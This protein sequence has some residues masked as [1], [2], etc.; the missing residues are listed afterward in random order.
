MRAYQRVQPLTIGELWAVAITLRIVLVE[1][2]RRSAERIVSSRAA[3]QEADALADRLLGEESREAELAGAALRGLEQRSLPREFAVQLDPAA[4]R[5]RSRGH[6]GPALA[7]RAS[8]APRAPPPTSSCARSTSAR[9]AMNVTVRNVITSMRLISAVD[10]A[11]FFESVSLVDEA[12]RAESDFAEM[13]FATRDRYRHA[14]EELARGAK[15]TE[16]EVARRALQAARRAAAEPEPGSDPDDRRRQDPGYFLI[17]GGRQAF[18]RE[19]GFRV[20]LKHPDPARRPRRRHAGLPRHDRGPQ[21]ADPGAARS[22]ALARSGVDGAT[23]LLLGLLALIPASDAALALVNRGVT[24]RFGPKPLPGLELRDGVPPSLRTLVVVPTLLTTRAEI[25][26]QIERLEV[27]SL[28]SP[29]ADLRFALLSDWT[30]SA[31]ESAPGDD[32]LLAAAV[33]GIA[34]LNHSHGAPRTASASCCSTAARVWNASR[35][36]VDGLGAQARQAPAS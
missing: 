3:R 8:R 18:E 19:L 22:Y 14:I 23:L 35:G 32:E 11:D 10:W 6:A 12:L 2:L 21:R 31:T 24:R 29:D 5:P 27:H 1:N 7:G 17:A 4:A 28:A 20:P 9:R 25:E 16:L 26:E 34:R 15:Q 33:E 36:Q 13:D 30:D